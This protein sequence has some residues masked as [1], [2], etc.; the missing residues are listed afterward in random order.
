MYTSCV[1]FAYV[2]FEFYHLVVTLMVCFKVYFLLRT[3]KLSLCYLTV[4][5]KSQEEKMKCCIGHLLKNLSK[6]SHCA[7]N[8]IC[9]VEQL[10]IGQL[11]ANTTLCSQ[12]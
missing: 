11:L 1:I 5:T 4:L 3:I 10:R 7:H 2:Y 12:T 8:L 9:L 6:T